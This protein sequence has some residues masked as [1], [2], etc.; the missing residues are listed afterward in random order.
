MIREKKFS[1]CPLSFQG[2]K[3]S[4]LVAS[5]LRRSRSAGQIISGTRSLQEFPSSCPSDGHLPEG[6]KFSMNVSREG[7]S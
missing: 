7:L 5:R 4:P 1:K 6:R 3:N 2:D